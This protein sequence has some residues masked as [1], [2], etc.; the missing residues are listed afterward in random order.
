MK[1]L[2]AG[3][4]VGE[5]GWHLF[6]Y[7]AYVRKLSR[8]YDKTIIIGRP[9]LGF[10]YK[11]FCDEYIEFNPESFKTDAYRCHGAK[12]AN[13]IIKSIHH[14]DYL[15]GEFDIGA[16]YVGKLIDT[17]GKFTNEQEFIKYESNLSDKSYDVIFH[18]RNK[19]TGAER[20]W[21]KTQW[22]SLRQ[23]MPDDLT[24]ACIGNDEAFHI[25]GTDDLRNI[26]LEELISIFNNSK[27][28]VGPSSG[29]MHLASL[30]GLK[31]LVWTS[32][33]NRPR[34]EKDWNPFNTE[35]VLYTEGEWNP[36]PSKI[37]EL[38][39]NELKGESIINRT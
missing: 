7:Q 35:V 22:E 17:N 32:E 28:I 10:I 30:S 4:Y 16:H 23:L 29:P 36:K 6:F 14:T 15:T 37:K 5:F 19:S 9:K 13:H 20:N 26:D 3:P 12:S 18:C 21:G 31:H 8:N 24:Y 1:T 25:S 11:D 34:Y 2:L 39:L 27:I 33:F 38:I